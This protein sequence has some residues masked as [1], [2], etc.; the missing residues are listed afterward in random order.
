MG[1]PT[2]WRLASLV[3]TALLACSSADHEAAPAGAGP[4]PATNAPPLPKAEAGFVDVPPQP[5]AAVSIPGR[6]FYAFHAADEHPETKPLFVLFNG[7]PHF[8]TTAG[9]L[10][11]GTA[12]YMI[13]ITAPVGST[14]V[15]NPDDL[16]AT[17][18]AW[19]ADSRGQGP[20]VAGLVLVQPMVVW[21]QFDAHSSALHACCAETTVG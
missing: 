6:M 12:P 7:G 11:F 14:P 4:T 19:R 5:T 15:A 10:P 18:S 3:L 2:V 16:A 1:M 9:L 17:I 20:R 13:D 21:A 8:A